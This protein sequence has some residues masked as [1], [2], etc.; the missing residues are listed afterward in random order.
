M[1]F[2]ELET[3][4]VVLTL[5]FSRI[6]GLIWFLPI[7]RLMEVRFRLVLCLFLS[8]LILPAQISRIDPIEAQDPIQILVSCLPT[9]FLLGMMLAL[10]VQLW[11]AAF[12]L[13][14]NVVARLAGMSFPDLVMPNASGGQ[15][16]P[17]A[18]FYWLGMLCFFLTG[19]HR[20]VIAGVLE[21]FS[22]VPLLLQW[23]AQGL[24]WL[25]AS[26]PLHCF[27]AGWRIASPLIL[28]QL[29]AALLIGGLSRIMPTVGN[30]GV[31]FGIQAIV[32]PLGMLVLMTHPQ[33]LINFS[34]LDQISKLFAHLV[35][36]PF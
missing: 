6:S 21:S 5:S 8:L 19:S 34:L 15:P 17:A 13:A 9:N 12:T 11:F 10:I 35:E 27:A 7:C 33:W 22:H 25:T 24:E 28:C 30:M 36:N 26:L 3:L 18:W 4:S 16:V 32:L 1:F 31:L 14:G 29:I 23:H 2:P 20:L